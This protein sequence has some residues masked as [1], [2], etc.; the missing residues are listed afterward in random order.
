MRI[1][2]MATA[3]IAISR[4][5]DACLRGAQKAVAVQGAGR[6]LSLS[7]HGEKR[8]SPSG[9]FDRGDG[10]GVGV[11]FGSPGDRRGATV[12]SGRSRRLR[13]AKSRPCRSG[14]RVS[15]LG[16]EP[17][18]SRRAALAGAGLYTSQTVKDLLR[19]ELI[20]YNALAGDPRLR[21]RRSI[22]RESTAIQ[23]PSRGK[24]VGALSSANAFP[25][26]RLPV[27]P[28]GANSW[29]DRPRIPG[30]RKPVQRRAV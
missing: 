28:T 13:K 6:A 10:P 7:V 11:S 8:C 25:A 18:N 26:S 30:P 1:D 14:L 5:D 19:D 4:N 21:D 2:D 17:R 23:Y 22:R 27:P 24:S 9:R 12:A 15:S 3:K 16:V 20:G 29:S